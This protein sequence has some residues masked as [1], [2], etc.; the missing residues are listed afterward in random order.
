MKSNKLAGQKIKVSTQKYLDIAEI[1]NDTVVLKDGTL[2]A[3][4]LVSSINFALKSEDEQEAI[5]SAYVSFLNY[6]DFSLQ[7]VIQSRKLNIDPYLQS[8]K[9]QEAKQTNELLRAQ[10]ADY[11]NFIVQLVELGD[12]MS[13]QF[14]VVVPYSPVSQQGQKKFWDR[15]MAIFS[16][17]KI[18]KLKQE[19][20]AKYKDMLDKRVE[21]VMSSLASIGLNSVRLDTQ[22]LIELYYNTYN[23]DTYEQE[24]LHNIEELRIAK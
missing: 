5:I 23:P 11:R 9:E 20:F 6:L 10:I 3:V 17:G 12:I 4:L 8:L 7:I 13:K 18:V 1:R 22:S 21:F 2:R 24:K 16:A 19:K 14:Y 15:V